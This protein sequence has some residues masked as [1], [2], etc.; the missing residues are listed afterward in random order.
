M[1]PICITCITCSHVQC[2][3]M[4]TYILYEAHRTVLSAYM[5]I[6][7]NACVFITRALFS[8]T[9]Q[10]IRNRIN[11]RRACTTSRNRMIEQRN[12][13]EW[14]VYV[15][16]TLPD[17]FQASQLLGNASRMAGRN[18]ML[19][20]EQTFRFHRFVLLTL[21][22]CQE[23]R[24]ERALANTSMDLKDP[25]HIWNLGPQIGNQSWNGNATIGRAHARQKQRA[26]KDNANELEKAR[27]SHM[28]VRFESISP[29]NAL[30]SFD[31]NDS[32]STFFRQRNRFRFVTKK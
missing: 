12:E 3:P 30:F 18:Q 1:L 31:G 19:H 22:R 15:C 8:I 9:S 5:L 32:D 11:W 28:F 29:V 13:Q 7:R 20:G 25:V 24:A 6:H 27:F 16:V 23:H 2:A 14:C 4:P 26:K 10:S 21:H 17:L